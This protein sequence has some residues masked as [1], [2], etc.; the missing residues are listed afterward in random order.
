MSADFSRYSGNPIWLADRGSLRMSK[1]SRIWFTIFAKAPPLACLSFANRMAARGHL[2]KAAEEP[3]EKDDRD[4]YADQPKQKTPTHNF[5][6]LVASQPNV[7]SELKFHARSNVR[8]PTNRREERVVNKGEAVSRPLRRRS[9]GSAPTAR[10]SYLTTC[11]SHRQ[12]TFGGSR[13]AFTVSEKDGQFRDRANPAEPWRLRRDLNQEHLRIFRPSVHVSNAH[14]GANSVAE[15]R[16]IDALQQ[17][18][19]TRNASGDGARS[20]KRCSC[21]QARPLSRV[22]DSTVFEFG[23]DACEHSEQTAGEH[24]WSE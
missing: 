24:G 9:A 11:A 3:D 19:L 7:G 12:Q 5:L 22:C 18:H 21:A 14:C 23:A 1:S 13:I 17:P 20:R 8:L 10:V 4:R 2:M 6:L 16:L 15:G